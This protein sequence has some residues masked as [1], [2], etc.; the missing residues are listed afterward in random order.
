M[1]AEQEVAALRLMLREMRAL[2]ATGIDYA[3]RCQRE[4]D[5]A[6]REIA[7]LRTRAEQAEAER[8]RVAFA[9]LTSGA[10]L[11]H[12]GALC[13]MTDDEYPLKAV[14][15][16]VAEVARLRGEYERGLREAAALAKVHGA[17]SVHYRILSLLDAAPAAEGGE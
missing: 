2:D 11:L 13:E 9:A 8:E 10:D 16:V 14:E 5:T 6:Q 15:R 3:L 12:I 4:R 1:S 17:I 7:T